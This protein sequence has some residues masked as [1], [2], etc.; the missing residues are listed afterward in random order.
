LSCFGA[1]LTSVPRRIVVFQQPDGETLCSS[2]GFSLL[3][4]KILTRTK[5]TNVRQVPFKF[6]LNWT[7]HWP[8]LRG[9]GVSTQELY[10]PIYS[11]EFSTDRL[12]RFRGIV[13]SN[14]PLLVPRRRKSKKKA[15][16]RESSNGKTLAAGSYSDF[17]IVLVSISLR[18]AKESK[19]RQTQPRGVQTRRRQR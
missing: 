8:S 17:N 4:G 5:P 15:S 11:G 7:L 14:T 13:L 1:S 3:R 10:A 19:Q 2:S 16:S 18:V 9:N 12:V 6:I